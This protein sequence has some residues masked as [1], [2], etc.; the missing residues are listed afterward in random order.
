MWKRALPIFLVVVV[1]LAVFPW[2]KSTADEWLPIDPADLKMTSEPRAPGAPAIY[3]YRQVD[4]KDRGRAN[5]EFNYVRI[6]ILTEQGRDYANVA[7]PYVTDTVNISGIRA[8]TIH[9]DGSIVN[10]DGRAYDKMVEKTKT[11]KFKAKVF[12]APDVQVGSIVEYRFAY[13]FADYQGNSGIVVYQSHWVV[14]DDLYTRKAVFSLLPNEEF[15]LRWDWPAGL[16]AGTEPPKQGP[17]KIIRMTATDIPPFQEEEL[18]PPPD[19]LK[20][21]VEFIYSDEI[22]VESDPNKYWHK[23]GKKQ[24]DRLESFLGRKKDLEAAVGQI[25]SPS[26]TPEVKLQKIYARVQQLRNLSYE[27]RKSEEEVKRDKQKKIETAADMLKQGYGYGSELTWLFLGLARAAGFE[28]YGVLLAARSEHLFSENRMNSQ[29]L[30]ANVV[31][32]K[33]GGKELYFDPGAAFV[34]YGLLPW[35]ETA[36][37]GM[38]LDKDGG[39]WATTTVPDS[40]ESQIQ[41]K[42][43]LKLNLEGGLEGKVVLTF[44]GLEAW[45]WRLREHLQDDEARKKELEEA[46]QSYIPASAEVELLKQPEWKSSEQPVV[47]EF[48]VKIPG[49]VSGAGKRAMM[50]VGLFSASE[51]D[52]FTHSNRVHPIFF[53]YPY[54]KNDDVTVELPEGWS[55]STIPNALDKDAKGAEYKLKVD[56][57]KR[58][59]HITRSVRSDLVAVPKDSYEALRVFFSVVRSGDEQQIV[60]QPGAVAAGK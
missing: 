20:Y 26:D 56:D 31:L 22:S 39:S 33:V 53:N 32:I 46:L 18:M 48:Q 5:V 29:E 58:S 38:K 24:N 30:D 55:V 23:W 4:R 42:A 7:I 47:A 21:R 2:R 40:A 8:R 16:P 19:E 25:V 1:C 43:D 6:K 14:S 57:Q 44:T 11:R 35:P 50:P 10:F 15:S 49:W 45:S 59:V 60:L 41:R 28:G 13:D 12:T 3:L 36:A 54:Q 27:P 17:D 51:K 34:P 52:L 9:A 37:K